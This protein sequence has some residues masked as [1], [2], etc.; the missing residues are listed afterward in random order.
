MYNKKN[1]LKRFLAPPKVYI[2]TLMKD[3]MQWEIE[4]IDKSKENR[5]QNFTEPHDCYITYT[6]D[7]KNGVNY[8][9]TRQKKNM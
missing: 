2:L 9:R 7:I 6:Q 4:N 5:G 1:S 8:A 3:V